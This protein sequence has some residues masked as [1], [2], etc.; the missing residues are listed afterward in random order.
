MA[1]SIPISD[2]LYTLASSPGSALSRPNVPDSPLLRK[3][4][5]KD[6]DQV[7]RGRRSA[8]SLHAVSKEALRGFTFKR[9]ESAEGE[10]W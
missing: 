10:G 4:R 2:E 7:S 6:A 8:K 3:L 9:A 1:Q 5:A